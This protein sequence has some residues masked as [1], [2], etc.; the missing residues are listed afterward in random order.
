M[1]ISRNATATGQRW[2]GRSLPR[3]EDVRL[4]SGRGRFVDDLLPQ[5]CLFLEF[6]RSPYP[7][8]TITALD[9]DEARA[10]DGVVAVITADDMGAL[11]ESAIN[12]VLPDMAMRPLRPLAAGEVEA[13]GQPVAAVVATSLAAARDA[14]QSIYLDVEPRSDPDGSGDTE[15]YSFHHS[16]GDLDAAFSRAAHVVSVSVEHSLVAPMALEPRATLAQ[17]SGGALT[18]WAS[19]QA[20]FRVRDDLARIL[21]L[22]TSR[23]RV[24]APD[25]GGAFGGKASIYP[26]DVVVAWAARH[27]K[28]PVKWCATRGEELLAATQGRGAR[29]EGA[30]ALSE[31]GKLLGLRVRLAFQ[32]GH[33]MPYSS[34]IPGRNASRILP[35]PYRVE[36]IEID[37]KGRATNRAAVGIYRGAGRPEAAMLLE[38]LMDEAARRLGID[39]LELRRRNVIDAAAFP[40]ATPTGQTL[41]SGDYAR[42]LD[43]VSGHAGYEE[44][45]AQR[46]RRREA[47]EVVGLGL[48]LYIE[49]C[50]QGWESADV[51]F[52]RD[53]TFKVNTGSSA[54]GQGRETAFAQIAADALDVEPRQVT[55]REGDTA[56][57]GSGIGA[58]ASRSTAIGGSAVVRA[59]AELRSQLAEIAAEL[60]QCDAASLAFSPE[61]VSAGSVAGAQCMSWQVLADHASANPKDAPDAPLLTGSVVYH[62]EGEAWSSGC[63][64]ALVSIDP[65]TGEPSFDKLA[66]VDD[67]GR[68]VNPLLVRGQ[69]VGGMVQG[70]G[71][72]LMER[73][74]YDAEGQLLTGSLMDYAVPRAIDV[75]A[76]EIDKFET[77]SPFNALGVKGVGEAGCIG[78]PA[79]IFNAV[80]DAVAPFGSND[81]QMPL[82]SERIWRALQAR[83]T[84]QELTEEQ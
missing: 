63:C 56:D 58:L 24:V 70:L 38:R 11:G 46:D 52:C 59:C 28:A 42:L 55:V 78:I 35:G 73:V 33:W 41:D 66:W 17:W 65:S 23:V 49:P 72:A 77:P 4:V 50:G 1:N 16:D 57:L 26:E 40:Y 37:L 81:L 68:V 36:A 61:G 21:D 2:I 6:L 64:L 53:G 51:S 18:V 9:V 30:L 83:Q 12:N 79:A 74:V 39:P 32:L 47:G 31:D 20:P 10:A 45:R 69:L 25:V 22:P 84:E 43:K 44:L 60:L 13:P 48:A 15:M 29:S 82:T 80:S 19:T 71:E 5:G 54:Q 62:A 34:A 67:A 27:L 7:Q 76:I 8:G 75:P 14:A 3:V